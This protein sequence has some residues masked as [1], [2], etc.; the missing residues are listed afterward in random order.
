MA[1]EDDPYVALADTAL[2]PLGQA[3][4][5]GSFLV[6]YIP[7]LK[8]VPSWMPGASFKRN[9]RVWRCQAREMLENQFRVVKQKMEAPGSSLKCLS[10]G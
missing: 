8:Y 7:A 1:N 4:I 10:A 3:A 9:A 2:R 6:D 5:F